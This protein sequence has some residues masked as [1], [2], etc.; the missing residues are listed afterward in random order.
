MTTVV[1]GK[2][3]EED[4][5]HWDGVTRTAS[6]RDGTGGTVT[7]NALGHEVDVLEVYGS[8]TSYTWQT[9][10]DCIT[11]IG[12]AA[13]T[14]IFKPGTWTIDQNLTIGSNFVCR[15]PAGC[16][17]NVSS[18]KTLTFSGPVIRDYATW[19]SG[20]GTVTES[21]TRTYS[22]THNFV[23][24]TVQGVVSRGH[25]A[26][27]TL[28][29]NASDATND[30]DI[31]VG[32]CTDS[33]GV[34]KIKLSSSI[35]KRL[36]AAWAVGTNQG[37]LDTG[38]IANDVYHIWLI[39]RSDTGVVDALFS[40][41]ATAPTMPTSYDYKRRIGAI[42]RASAAILAFTQYGDHFRLSISVL[43]INIT[44][45]GTAA[46]TRT[47]ASVP[48]GVR[49]KSLLNVLTFNSTATETVYVSELA[50]SDQAPADALAPLHNLRSTSTT[51]ANASSTQIEIMTN[52]SAQIRSRNAVG[53]ANTT[54]RIATLGWSDYRGKSD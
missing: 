54:L 2:I 46:V 26:G 43:D 20:S 27:L 29:N 3:L 32:E 53:D 40:A 21:G 7:G 1:K 9:V 41:S 42:I 28:S 50:A 18:G 47:L 16:V 13:A 30:I 34:Y 17:F 23:S 52:T 49:V 36:D 10:N 15:I 35:T 19:T 38:S 8:G 39:A 5:H 12:S 33:T 22:G 14:L 11:R 45:P 25:I 51:A 37:G 48:D 6:R 31:A 4:I 44:N 24:A